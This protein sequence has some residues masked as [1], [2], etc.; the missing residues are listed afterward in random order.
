MRTASDETWLKWR[1]EERRAPAGAAGCRRG[2]MHS[3]CPIS[4]RLPS[5]LKGAFQIMGTKQRELSKGSTPRISASSGKVRLLRIG[6]RQVGS[7]RVT[8]S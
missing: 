5:A 6:D 8:S 2:N 7:N 3:P 4:S 1:R